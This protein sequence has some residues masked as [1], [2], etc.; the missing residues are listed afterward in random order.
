MPEI[1][2]TIGVESSIVENEIKFFQWEIP[3][4]RPNSNNFD[5]A[6]FD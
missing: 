2:T 3:Q 4:L 5:K 6:E 1:S